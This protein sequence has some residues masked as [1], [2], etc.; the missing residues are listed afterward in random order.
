MIIFTFGCV[1]ALMAGIGLFRQQDVL[2]RLSVASIASVLGVFCLGAGALIM[3]P[4]FES[5][6]KVL[7]SL[8]VLIIGSPVG[9]QILARSVLAEKDF[10]AD[11][12]FHLDQ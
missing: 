12:K 1:L 2:T 10:K 7:L 8:F 5:A 9:S 4:S 3:A 11:T 6:W